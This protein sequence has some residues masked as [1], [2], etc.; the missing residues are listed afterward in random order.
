MFIGKKQLSF[1]GA[2]MALLFTSAIHAGVK[3]E[4]E[5]TQ[6]KLAQPGEHYR[7]TLVLRNTGA[8]MAEAKVYQTDYSFASDGSNAYG[9]PGRLPRS[10]AKWIS[11]S[12]ELVQIPPSGT[13][14]LDFEVKVPADKG[15]S[16]TYWS[17]V[18][19]EPIT[20]ASAEAAEPLPERTTRLTQ[21][22]RYGVQI[23]THLGKTGEAGLVFTNPQIVKENGQ[24]LFTIDVENTGQRWLSPGLSLELYNQS[25]APVGKFEGPAKRLYPATSARF[26]MDLGEV[27]DGKYLG[28]VVADGTGD[29][30]FGANVELEIE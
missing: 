25:G 12:R 15:L 27:P 9:A 10:N 20:E 5:L 13:E 29:N 24:R 2:L 17:M 30:L 7:G 11:L 6:E 19:I 14:R 28:L 1:A 18:M 21:V 3:L 26:Q 4:S 22:V 16:G 8:T 23:V